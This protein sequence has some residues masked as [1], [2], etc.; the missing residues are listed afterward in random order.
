MYVNNLL[1]FIYYCNTIP[2]V[3]TD[4]TYKHYIVESRVKIIYK[5][6]SKTN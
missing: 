4:I 3:L 6:V 2:P 5:E 1:S